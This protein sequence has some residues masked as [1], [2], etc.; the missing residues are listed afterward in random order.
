MMFI[1]KFS[2]IILEDQ[3]KLLMQVEDNLKQYLAVNSECGIEYYSFGKISEKKII[4]KFTSQ[5]K[6]EDELT[7]ECGIE[8]IK[9]FAIV[10]SLTKEYLKFNFPMQNFRVELEFGDMLILPCS[11]MYPHNL[12]RECSGNILEIEYFF[13]KELII[14]TEINRPKNYVL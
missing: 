1:K 12:E 2:N 3:S 10:I 6:N 8:K 11:F 4:S 5:L 7:I 14:K 9:N 13:K